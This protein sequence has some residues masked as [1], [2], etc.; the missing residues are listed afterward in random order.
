MSIKM[1]RILIADDQPEVRSALHFLLDQQPHIKVV[2]EIDNN[3]KLM[4]WFSANQAD[5]VLLDW[6]LPGSPSEDIITELRSTFPKVAAV[7]LDSKPQTEKMAINAGAAGF[8]SKNETPERLLKIIEN[9]T[10]DKE[11]TKDGNR[12]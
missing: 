12:N 11:R 2:G 8:V 6:D 9:C 10:A 4:N 3:D 1:T 7:V 5:M